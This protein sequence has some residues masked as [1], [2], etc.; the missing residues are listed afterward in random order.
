MSGC[1][2]YFDLRLLLF[3]S[4]KSENEHQ[5]QNNANNDL[6]HFYSEYHTELWNLCVSI[7]NTSSDTN[8]SS[9]KNCFSLDEDY[10]YC[11][12][13][14]ILK[15][16]SENQEMQYDL[17]FD[18][19]DNQSES[20]EYSVWSVCYSESDI[21]DGDFDSG[22]FFTYEG[23]EDMTS[24]SDSDDEDEFMSGCVEEFEFSGKRIVDLNHIFEEIRKVNEHSETC[25]FNDMYIAGSKKGF[26]SH[27]RFVCRKCRYSHVIKTCQHG[28]DQFDF[29]YECVLASMLI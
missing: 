18:D 28:N 2:T 22:C 13:F 4:I 14:N 1:W 9:S 15:D 26:V 20:S 10:E 23:D 17:D 16:D 3:F 21:E 11:D 5:S 6:R 8:S 29:N 12:N 24:N 7:T 27:F 25:N 19:I